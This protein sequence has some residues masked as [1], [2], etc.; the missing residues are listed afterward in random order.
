MKAT[1]A[2]VT[3]VLGAASAFRPHVAIG[4][5]PLPAVRSRVAKAVPVMA[6]I[7]MVPDTF[8]PLL[9]AASDG[10][11]GTV[12]APG[13]VLPLGG[14]LAV[15]TALLPVLLRPGEEA[16]DSMRENEK[17]KDVGK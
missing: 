10:F 12:D 13:W 6:S 2:L 3:L 1:L 9:I 7:D 17:E 15:A 16:L 11:Y 8:S 14:L 4:R 5:R